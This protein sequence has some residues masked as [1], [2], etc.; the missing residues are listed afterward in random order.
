MLT[1]FRIT[2]SW[3][4]PLV[5]SLSLFFFSRFTRY[6]LLL[7]LP[8]ASSGAK[9]RSYGRVIKNF[10][11]LG[12][13]NYGKWMRAGYRYFPG[14][15]SLSKGSD[16]SGKLEDTPQGK[17]ILSRCFLL[18]CYAATNTVDAIMLRTHWTN[19]CFLLYGQEI[20]TW[21]LI[22]A[23]FYL[24]SNFLFPAKKKKN[25]RTRLKSSRNVNDCLR[26]RHRL[27]SLD[28]LFFYGAFRVR[29][30]KRFCSFTIVKI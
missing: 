3:S 17:T 1:K 2:V 22:D 27:F 7:P 13:R 6:L 24:Y 5:F 28:C 9:R 8:R 29:R 12:G 20:F 25:T 14:C 19:Y 23:F 21:R 30:T 18:D 11:A 26:N 10:L 15:F 4:K 16:G